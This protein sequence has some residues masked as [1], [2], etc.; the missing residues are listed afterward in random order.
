MQLIYIVTLIC[1]SYPAFDVLTTPDAVIAKVYMNE[2]AS[3]GLKNEC[4]VVMTI[5]KVRHE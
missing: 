2:L 5:T 1:G 3:E 4:K